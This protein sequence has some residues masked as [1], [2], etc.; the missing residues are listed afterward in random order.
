[1][2]RVFVGV[3]SNIQPQRHV[4]SALAELARCFGPV[5]ASPAYRSR[6]VGFEGD[7]FINLVVSFES[8]LPPARLADK[9]H[10]IEQA[11]GRQRN[12]KRF[13]PRVIDL[14]I[15]MVGDFVSAGQERPQLPRGE[16][17]DYA[18]VLRPLAELAPDKIHPVEACR[19]DALWAQRRE[20]ID[21]GDLQPVSLTLPDGVH[22]SAP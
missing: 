5:Q 16:I 1:M 3:G 2:A 22:A 18:F 10:E 8:A 7:D 12:S 19:C 6:A 17:L 11:C 4:A 14:D 21:K 9:L 13:A 15:L 20:A